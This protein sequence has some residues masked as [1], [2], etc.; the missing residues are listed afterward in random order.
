MDVSSY[1]K[2]IVNIWRGPLDG[3][4]PTVGYTIEESTDQYIWSD[5]SGTTWPVDPGSGTEA[6]YDANL[7][8]RWM[9]ISVVLAGTEPRGTCWAMGFLELRES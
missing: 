1:S 3:T 4:S 8:K 5:C 9:R 6:Q 7:T 2:A